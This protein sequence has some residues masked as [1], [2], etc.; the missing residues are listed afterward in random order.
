VH[1]CGGVYSS[2]THIQRKIHRKF[3]YTNL[4]LVSV[5]LV[6]GS[7]LNLDAMEFS[8]IISLI[9]TII[10]LMVSWY[11]IRLLRMILVPMK[12]GKPFEAGIFVKSRKLA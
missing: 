3:I 4:G 10:L 6:E 1:G 11:S 5:K 8:I 12:E 7:Y 9:A 2:G